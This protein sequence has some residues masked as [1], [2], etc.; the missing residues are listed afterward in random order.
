MSADSR[1]VRLN[2]DFDDSP[3]VFTMSAEGQL[4]WIKLLCHVKRDG[5]GGKVRALEPLVAHRKWG[6][7]EEHIVKML[8][9]AVNDG[10]L[11]IE[12][13]KWCLSNWSKYQETDSTAAERKRRQRAKDSHA[14]HDMS[15]RD[16]RD[17]CRVTET[18][19]ETYNPQTPKG[20]LVE[21]LPE[22]LRTDRVRK[23]WASYCEHRRGLRV[24]QYSEKGLESLAKRLSHLSES[25]ICALIDEVI[26]RNWQGI[27]PSLLPSSDGSRMPE[28]FKT[29]AKRLPT[30]DEQR[31]AS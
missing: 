28:R 8:Q 2:I 27:D 16:N 6:V 10:A 23:A 17:D 24:R 4:A 18:E 9:A 15:R 20:E 14:G 7:G 25:Q 5:R 11:V 3:W 30:Y 26:S 13:G 29:Q 12:D 22:P 19:T 1:W 31:R 21:L